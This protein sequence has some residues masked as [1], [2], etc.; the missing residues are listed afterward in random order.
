MDS[1]H[2]RVTWTAEARGDVDAAVAFIAEDSLSSA[3]LVLDRI[4]AAASSLHSMPERG[5]VVPEWDHPS[6]RELM[7]EPFRLLYFVEENSVSV[8]AVIH[9]RRNFDRWIDD[10]QRRVDPR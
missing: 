10:V 1:G 5:R 3:L 9:Q 6:V 7:V 2:R 4:L 8:V